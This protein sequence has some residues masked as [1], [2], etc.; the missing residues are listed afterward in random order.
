MLIVTKNRYKVQI[1]Y[2]IRKHKRLYI[3]KR[4]KQ[5]R[6]KDIV[7]NYI[8]CHIP[9]NCRLKLALAK[10]SKKK[11]TKWALHSVTNI[12]PIS[13]TVPTVTISRKMCSA[14][15]SSSFI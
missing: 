2:E 5:K 4:N 10:T 13:P 7:M 11:Q 12:D 3:F 9:H 15:S 1:S 8:V 6:T 14:F